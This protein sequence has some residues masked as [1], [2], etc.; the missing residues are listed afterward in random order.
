MLIRLLE[1]FVWKNHGESGLH[2][3]QRSHRLLLMQ[4]S[5]PIYLLGLCGPLLPPTISPDYAGFL[6]SSR[7]ISAPMRGAGWKSILRPKLTEQ[8]PS[9]TVY[10]SHTSKVSSPPNSGMQRPMDRELLSRLASKL[11]TWLGMNVLSAPF[12]YSMPSQLEAFACFS[13]FIE[14][15]CP[16]YVQPTLVGVHRGLKVGLALFLPL[17]LPMTVARRF[18][19][20]VVAACHCVIVS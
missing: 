2:H 13:T 15:S 3:L 14:H 4:T 17:T 11:T 8:G 20:V 1:A 5:H 12:L 18:F 19:G 6:N 7:D 10:P 9:A 16:L